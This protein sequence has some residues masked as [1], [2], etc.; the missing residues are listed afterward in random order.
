MTTG[1]HTTVEQGLPVGLIAQRGLEQA[2]LVGLDAHGPKQTVHAIHG[3]MGGACKNAGLNLFTLDRDLDAFTNWGF[4]KLGANQSTSSPTNFSIEVVGCWRWACTGDFL[5]LNASVVPS[6]TPAARALERIKKASELTIEALAPL[7]GVSRRALHHWLAD[8]H[9]SQRNE[10]RLR[11]LA[12]ATEKIAAAVSG[13]VREA[14]LAR[15]PGAPRIYDLLAEAKYDAAIARVTGALPVTR[16]L[17]YPMPRPPAVSL[18]AMIDALHD[19]PPSMNGQLD[20]RL[21][22]RLR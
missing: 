5:A 10:E 21:T 9:I 15:V 14:L 8:G 17:V 2:L 16:P 18:D 13:S 4:W 20:R 1:V 19:P 3:L 12:E 11:A 22:K 7:V 6:P